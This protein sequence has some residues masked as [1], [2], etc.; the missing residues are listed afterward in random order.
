MLLT[1]LPVAFLALFFI[2]RCAALASDQYVGCPELKVPGL[3]CP[4]VLKSELRRRGEDPRCLIPGGQHQVVTVL[5]LPEK[6]E[7]AVAATVRVE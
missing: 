6:R 5:G 4:K 1:D 7:E 2:Q 3:R